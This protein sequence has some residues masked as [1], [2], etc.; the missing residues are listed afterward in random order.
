MLGLEKDPRAE[1]AI[2]RWGELKGLRACYEQDWEELAWM[3]RGP[4]RGGFTAA[5]PELVR[6]KKALSSAPIVAQSNFASGLFGTMTNPA[7]RW[8]GLKTPDDFTDDDAGKAWLDIVNKRVLNSFSPAVSPFYSAAIQIFSDVSTFGN[9]A[10]YDEVRPAEGKIM[11]VTLSL[12]EVVYAIDAFGRV[13]EF[14]R[15]TKLSAIQAARQFGLDALPEKLRDKAIAGNHTDKFEVYQHVRLN[16]DWW[17]RALGP[18]GKRWVSLHVVADGASVVREGGYDDMPVQAPRWE[19]DTGQT[20]GYGPGSIAMPDARVSNQ[21]DDATLRAAQFAADP[22]LLAPDRETWAL[23]GAVRPGSTIYGGVNM[24]GQRMVA[25]LDRVGQTGLT[26]DMYNRRIENI[27]DAF[28]WS[29]MNLAGRSGMT[30]TEIIERQEE[31]QRLMAPHIGRVQEEYL[32]PKIA[33][34]FFLLWRA[35]QLPPPPESM[36]EVPLEVE[37]LSAAAMAQKSAEGA[38][39]IRL[40]Q[41]VTPLAQIKPR[42]MDRISEDDLVEVLHEARGVPARVL[43]SREQADEME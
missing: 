28:H 5:N 32:A 17:P 33:R 39:V 41:D 1:D 31:K 10:Q 8:M 27:R 16:D 18:R 34:R 40:L 15:K 43:R 26:L 19:V 30:A 11:D 2:R 12:A 22:T 23:N 6:D 4:S 7:N 42:L 21:M 25:P 9:G 13:D 20:Y 35:R 29:L 3:I 24:S 37:Y 14:V 38:S 36:S